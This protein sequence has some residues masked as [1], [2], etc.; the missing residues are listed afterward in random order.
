MSPPVRHLLFSM[1]RHSPAAFVFT[2]ALACSPRVAFAV[3][4]KHVLVLHSTRSDT[5]LP[6]LV[7]SMLPSAL[8]AQLGAP[9]D[10]Y[11]ENLDAARFQGAAAEAAFRAYLAGK[12]GAR[13]FDLIIAMQDIA[14]NFVFNA[15]GLFGDAP[16]VFSSTGP[17]VQ[18]APDSTGVVAPTDLRPSL[19]LATALQP[20]VNQVFVV[21]GASPRDRIYE[22]L[23]HEQFASL[24][25]RL[26]FTYLSGL[27]TKDLEER[28][29]ALPDHSILYYLLVYQD[30]R[31]ENVNPLSYLE[32]IAAV[33]NRPTYS[34]VDSTLNRGVLGGAMQQQARL[35]SAICDLA[36]RVLKGEAADAIPIERISA[37]VNEVDWRQLRRWNVSDS[38]L[39]AG[40]I[41]VDRPDTL[42]DR[43]RT[44]MLLSLGALGIV[45]SALV[46]TVRRRSGVTSRRIDDLS[47]RLLDA[48]ETERS[49]IAHELHDDIGQQAAALS[50][51]LEHLNRLSFVQR[52]LAWQA[53]LEHA[54]DRTRD[55][56]DSARNLSHQL[57][58]PLLRLAGI[59]AALDELA[60]DFESSDASVTF[61]H[62]DVP[63]EIAQSVELSLFRIAQE[64]VHNAVR[65]GH[66]SHVKMILAG[67]GQNLRLVVSDNGAGFNVSASRGSGLGLL[68]IC[69][70]SRSVGGAS[71]IWS[72]P[73]NG[74]RLEVSIP[75]HPLNRP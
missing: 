65:H 52:P 59:V 67:N 63:R 34:W 45:T 5:Q 35:V 32:R 20:D 18:R 19:T 7:D 58:P 27:P 49:R 38:R 69:E 46:V 47:H 11:S 13:R 54:L 14:R 28:V 74:T 37:T 66:A 1:V 30:G 50:I 39:P 51:T 43:H 61:S 29:A 68:S 22:Q 57:H 10:Y 26:T 24:A 21:T 17:T 64:A 2:L 8:S 9:V 33:A 44:A 71:T 16:V 72:Q 23:A 48:Q 40:T 42:W 56:S 55:I 60:E 41:V 25:G 73:G 15:R 31:G 4:Q 12:Y 36:V 6:I 70:R 3:G 53:A 62:H 75:L